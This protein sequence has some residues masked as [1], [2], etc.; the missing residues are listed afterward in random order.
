MADAQ[1]LYAESLTGTATTAFVDA[2][3]ISAASFTANKKYLII[4]LQYIQSSSATN[5]PKAQLVHGTT[6][7]VFDNALTQ[8]ELSSGSER[9]QPAWF[10][11]FDQPA[12]TEDIKIQYSAAA[13]TLTNHLAQIL[14]IK[15]SD[16][17]TQS[18]D[19]FLTED[20]V[21]FTPTTEVD[22]ASVTF[23]VNGTD[24]WLLLGHFSFDDNSTTANLT[25][26]I[27]LDGTDINVATWTGEDVADFHNSILVRV[28]QPASG[29]R[30][31]KLQFSASASSHTITSNRIF[32]LNLGKFAQVA[33]NQN[34][35]Q[36]G[37]DVAIQPT[38]TTVATIGVT[39]SAT[40]DFVLIA[41]AIRDVGAVADA[42]DHR[43]QVND[44]GG[45]ASDPNYGDDIPNVAGASTSDEY[46]FVVFKKRSLTAGASRTVN[47][48]IS[49]RASNTTRYDE[50]GLVVFSVALA[51]GGGDATA[52]PAVVA[53]VATV[54]TPTLL[55][56][57]IT[58]PAVAAAVSTVP[59][60]TILTGGDATAAPAVVAGVG[61]VPAPTLSGT[62]TATPTV[63]AATGAVPAP[64]LS[65][66]AVATPS[67]V[68]GVSGITSPEVS[69][70]AIATPAVVAGASTVPTPPVIGGTGDI[71]A[72][73]STITAQASVPT[74]L[75]LTD[76]ANNLMR[77]ATG[78]YALSPGEQI[79]DWVAIP[80][81]TATWSQF[82]NEVYEFMGEYTISGVNG[83]HTAGRYYME[84]YNDD[85]LIGRADVWR[86][87][88][89]ETVK[90][91]IGYSY[92]LADET[93]SHTLTARVRKD[94]RSEGTTIEVEVS[95][96]RSKI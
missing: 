59:T 20:L 9:I 28:V 32:A 88:I 4:A 27:D 33:Y 49:H 17:F 46:Q 39:P 70:T 71:T 12:T 92:T 6:P 94:G 37:L 47:Y 2:V 63:V 75:V 41:H 69:S 26:K 96:T 83:T 3:T 91:S 65:G 35:T 43:I 34:A 82:V 53:A 68:A 18:T 44:G 60:P 61:D 30:T 74:T 7:T 25:T 55:A 72:S 80:L 76:V 13:G 67:T 57:A 52:T 54:P 15:L 81:S 64:T 14:A 31:A 24:R 10:V 22:K 19:W 11:V 5:N 42:D 73:P 40:G 51:G 78:S 90:G 85:T 95:V 23:T 79:D 29:S 66:T 1:V 56:A 89:A 58:E 45:L 87:E 62:A 38:W 77:L 16:D 8:W 84:V 21:D 86:T 48:D 50:N 93:A 36:E